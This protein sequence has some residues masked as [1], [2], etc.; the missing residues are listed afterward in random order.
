MTQQMPLIGIISVNDFTHFSPE[1]V[2]NKTSIAKGVVVSGIES[3]CKIC[4]HEILIVFE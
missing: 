3:K 2:R 4:L 1:N